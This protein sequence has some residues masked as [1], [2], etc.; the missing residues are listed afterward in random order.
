LFFELSLR[1]PQGVLV[2]QRVYWL[3]ILHMLA[4]PEARR[5]WQAGPVLEPL[6]QTGPWLKPQV[7]AL[8]TSVRGTAKFEPRSAKEAGLTVTVTNAGKLPAYPVQVQLE[9]DLYS[10]LWSDNYFWLAPGETATLQGTVRL[11]MAGLDPITRPRVASRN[12]LF[13][14]ISAWNARAIE[15]RP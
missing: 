10:V 9:P 6:T 13:L 15:L 11:D 14:R 2:S 8:A 5:R 12:D 7:A 1:D 4:D 3:R